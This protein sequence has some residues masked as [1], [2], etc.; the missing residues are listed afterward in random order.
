MN[1]SDKAYELAEW[2]FL[3]MPVAQYMDENV[4]RAESILDE[5]WEKVLDEW[6]EKTDAEINIAYAQLT[7]DDRDEM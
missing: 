2:D 7:G 6:N 1:I 3:H 5:A 4:L